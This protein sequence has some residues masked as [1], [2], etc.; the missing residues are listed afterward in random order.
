MPS[1]QGAK[2]GAGLESTGHVDAVK[3]AETLLV[4]GDDN[5]AKAGDGL[6]TEAF[7]AQLRALGFVLEALESS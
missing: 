3:E 4:V 2:T 1:R 5:S 7:R 6:I